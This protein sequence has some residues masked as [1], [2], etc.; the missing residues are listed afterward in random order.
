MSL[1]LLVVDH[2]FSYITKIAKRKRKRTLNRT[3]IVWKKL[4]GIKKN[5]FGISYIYT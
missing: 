4:I 3:I 1:N 2:H 5:S